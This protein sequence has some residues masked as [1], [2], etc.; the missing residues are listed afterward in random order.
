MMAMVFAFS[1]LF[2]LCYSFL[3]FGIVV[4]GCP[5]LGTKKKSTSR[6][7]RDQCLV[8]MSHLL[9]NCLFHD[10]EEIVLETARA[11]GNEYYIYIVEHSLY[12][13]VYIVEH[14]IVY[15]CLYI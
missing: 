5:I 1:F 14:S 3:V 6:T 4:V 11:L 8:E 7:E 15:M 13:R 10:N 12:I 2:V 9:S